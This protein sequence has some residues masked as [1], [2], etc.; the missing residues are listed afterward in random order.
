MLKAIC[1]YLD[2]HIIKMFLDRNFKENVESAK[3]ENRKEHTQVIH[4]SISRGEPKI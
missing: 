1:I 2:I 4:K 3:S